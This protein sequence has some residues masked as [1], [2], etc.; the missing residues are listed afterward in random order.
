[1]HAGSSPLARGLLRVADLQWPLPRIIPAR[2]GFTDGRDK[3]QTGLL[4]S[5]PLARGLPLLLVRPVPGGRDHPRSRGVYLGVPDDEMRARGSSPLARGLR[6]PRRRGARGS[7]IIPARAGFTFQFLVWCWHR[8]G[9]SP[10]A[11]DLRGAPSVAAY[12][13]GI[14]PARAG[15]T[16][17][18]PGRRGR[19]GDHP[20][21]RGVYGDGHVS[22]LPSSRII[23]ARAGFTGHGGRR[24]GGA[25]DHPRS[26][27]VYPRRTPS[28]PTSLGS[29][30]L[31]RGL[32]PPNERGREKRRIIP[33]RAGFTQPRPGGPA[34]G[35]DHPRSRGVYSRPPGRRRPTRGSSPLAR[36]LLLQSH[37]DQA[38]SWI[39]PARA[40]FTPEGG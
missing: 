22:A 27:G 17:H 21:S 10:L 35:G 13:T 23:P 28:G 34:P 14:I 6:P 24:E 7:R 39:I 9:S 19:P 15:F 2:A 29:S 32:P 3:V 33:A 5:S 38:F 16:R 12:I 31:A 11:R 40:G 30:P 18:Y 36:G 20:R 37:H 4:G 26:R 1:M 25:G 8:E